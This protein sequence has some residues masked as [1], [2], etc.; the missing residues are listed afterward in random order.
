MP[1]VLITGAASGIG[2]ATAHALAAA[3]YTLVLAD[4]DEAGLAETAADLADARTV[5]CD[6][7]AEADVA[8]AVALAVDAFGPLDVLVQSAGIEGPVAPLVQQSADDWARV[9]GVNVMG[10]FFGL[11]HA[12]PVMPRGGS[13]VNVASVAGLNAFPMHAAYAASKHA[14]VGLTRTAAIEAARAGVRVNA[15]CPGFTDTPMVEEGLRKMGQTVDDLTRLIPAR[16]LGT[17]D[18]IAAAIVYLCSDA[19]AYVTGQT[20]V[21]DGGLDAM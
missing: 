18:E 21:V 3:G 7:S 5:R 10:S 6:V 14:V 19:A 9:F 20:L 17:P 8:H 4:I 2:R 12:L 1:S 15:V 11:K 13:V 16:R